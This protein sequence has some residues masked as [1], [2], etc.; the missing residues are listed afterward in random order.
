M[1]V[2]FHRCIGPMILLLALTSA[3]SSGTAHAA[4]PTPEPPA[5]PLL[6]QPAAPVVAQVSF[7]GQDDLN[8]LAGEL[9]VWQID[10]SLQRAT[11]LLAPTQIQHLRREG[12][13]VTVDVPAT[14]QLA[15]WRAQAT[16]QPH[17]QGIPGFPCYRT[18]EETY[19]SL[20]Q[21][22]AAAPGLVQPVAVGQ[23]WRS[24]Q[25][26]GSAGYPIE[27]VILANQ[28]L[29]GTKPVFF[30][31]AAIHARELTTAEAAMRFA[32]RLILGY[33]VDPDATWLLDHTEIHIVP[34]ANPDGRKKAEGGLYWR[35]NIN[36]SL[37]CFLDPNSIGVDLNRNSS[38]RWNQ[39]TGFGCSSGNAC[40]VTYRGPQAASEPEVQAI[41][42]YM[43]T[44]FAD[45]RGTLDSDAAP[46]ATSGVMVSLHSYSPLILYPWGWTQTAAPNA[47]GLRTLARKFGYYTGYPVCQSGG[48]GCLYMTDG[49]TDDF[50]YGELG[51]AAFTFE[52]GSEFFQAC[53]VFEA[54]ILHG[55]LDALTYGAKAARR[56]YMAPAGPEI[57]SATPVVTAVLSGEPVTLT[58]V[59]DDTR[60]Y[61][62]DRNGEPP[63][64]AV[65][66]IQAVRYTI[67]TPSWVLCSFA[68]PMAPL[69]GAFDTAVETAV[70]VL[71]TV[72]WA[73]GRHLLFVEGQD[74]AG[75]WGVPT[76]I[77]VDVADANG[78]VPAYVARPA[79]CEKVHLPWIVWDQEP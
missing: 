17:A 50:A 11:M 1:S 35:K 66:A 49:T 16:A 73:P 39:C 34:Q 29:P 61:D 5:V 30:L 71:D 59:A 57:I 6:A 3:A 76:G 21:L 9:D 22:V 44:I 38:F 23:S 77:F 67:A 36:D 42:T 28:A 40:S 37:G 18:V 70:A 46:A 48:N 12:R 53:S 74:A 79:A 78:N 24:V 33:G 41:E 32:E 64:D 68:Q 62:A 47:E 56:P 4:P 7:A 65:Q 55:T 52:L 45:Q 2:T 69:D 60:R 31:M 20:A 8:R 63:A 27:G 15:N 72:G 13:A 75:V 51:V 26:S 14:A 25:T 10:P 43:R 19:A 54:S 58:V